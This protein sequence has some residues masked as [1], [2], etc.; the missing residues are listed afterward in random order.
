ML[1]EPEPTRDPAMVCTDPPP[2]PRQ[3]R[4]QA[5]PRHPS[6]PS[7]PLCLGL[8]G[9]LESPSSAPRFLILLLHFLYRLEHR[10]VLE[11]VGQYYE[12]DVA[13]AKVD[14]L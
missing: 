8:L 7:P 3:G 1:P 9:L 13:S 2:V 11:H 12:L 5:I 6:P 10:C 14:L 4:Y